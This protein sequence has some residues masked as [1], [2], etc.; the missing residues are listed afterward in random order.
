MDVID[1]PL[2]HELVL[3]LNLFQIATKELEAFKTPTLHLVTHWRKVLL[4]HCDIVDEERVV[5]DKDGVEVTL[6]PDS[7]D[8]ENIKDLIKDQILEK[9][10]LTALHAA[11]MYL[12]PRQKPIISELEIDD[13]LQREAIAIIKSTMVRNSPPT[14]TIDD[15]RPA[16]ATTRNR[17]P[18]KRKC[19]TIPVVLP[20]RGIND[21]SSTDDDDDQDDIDGA[22][23]AATLE[24]LVIAKLQ[25]YEA[26]TLSKSEKR[27]MKEVD[28]ETS[29]T[30]ILLWW[31][32]KA[33]TWPILA[34]AARSILAVPAASAMSENNFSDSGSTVSKKHN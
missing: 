8:L 31:K 19:A 23:N 2:L 11:A 32:S 18:R 27:M 10:M 20:R 6:P 5:K 9:F 21:F 15:K 3:F 4:E 1:Q 13:E 30:G 26:Y 34:R 17:H 28:E 29:G 16:L 14:P 25:A 33:S 22:P 7:K 12:D 24:I